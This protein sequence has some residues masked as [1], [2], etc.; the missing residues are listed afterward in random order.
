MAR[1]SI[2]DFLDRKLKG[3][4]L[5]LMTAYDYTFG[6]IV[7]EAGLEGILVGDSLS[8]VVQG[9]E[10]TLP[11]SMDEMVYH[12]KIVSRAVVNALVIGDMP[13]MSYQ[14]SVEEAVR[15]A[16]RF[17]KEG[18]AQAVKVE[19]GREILS[20]IRAM[21]AAEIPVMAHIGLT[22]QAIYRI[23]GFKVQGKTDEARTRLLEDAMMLEDAGVFSMVIEAVPSGLAKEITEK[24]TIPSI[25][26]GAGV[27]CDGQILVL[28]DC[29]GLFERFMPKFAKRYANL[30]EEAL[31]AL[32]T[33]RDE[34]KGG[35]FPS[36][37]ESFK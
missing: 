6:R 18:G 25:G 37:K 19:G 13:Y 31:K 7:D 33:Y 2:N 3:Q 23:G 28:H 14:V 26:I 21:I 36:E 10:N 34:V 30:K 9:L 1:I 24:L 15:N 8:M 29:I 4:K 17:I 22:P 32:C 35:I 12:T 27:H 5:A 20:Q 11:V 16:G